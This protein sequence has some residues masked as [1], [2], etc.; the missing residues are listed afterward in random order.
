MGCWVR[1][2]ARRQKHSWQQ[3]LLPLW[4]QWLTGLLLL[5]LVLLMGAAALQQEL[6][7]RVVQGTGGPR[8]HMHTPGGAC[9]RVRLAVVV[10]VPAALP[11]AVVQQGPAAAGHLGKLGRRGQQQLLVRVVAQQHPTQH[12]QRRRPLL[13]QLLA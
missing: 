5:G 2:Q 12:Q 1:Q 4:L 3:R 10:V 8:C 13:Q 9:L 7:V 6:A 11:T